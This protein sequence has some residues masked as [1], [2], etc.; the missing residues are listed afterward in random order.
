MLALTADH[1]TQEDPETSGA[2]MIDI[3]KLE[4]G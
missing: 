2:F 4:S 3:N 1:G